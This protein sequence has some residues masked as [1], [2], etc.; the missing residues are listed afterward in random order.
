MKSRT[1][2]LILVL[3]VV[4][5]TSTCRA[6]SI[7]QVIKHM[8]QDEYIFKYLGRGN[9]TIYL[10]YGGYD[11]DWRDTFEMSGKVVF[12]WPRVSREFPSLFRQIDTC[13]FWRNKAYMP[14][15]SRDE[16]TNLMRAIAVSPTLWIDQTVYFKKRLWW[17]K[18]ARITI[19]T[20]N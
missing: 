14:P 6:Q 17:Y 3:L 15:P 20:I 10:L 16:I 2:R 9:D 12:V 13:V 19:G 5:F 8:K 18:Y 1:A 4:C 7:Q 11:E